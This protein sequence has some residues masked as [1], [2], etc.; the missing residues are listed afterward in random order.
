MFDEE[1]V[2]PLLLPRAR[3]VLDQMHASGDVTDYEFI[4]VDDGSLDGTATRLMS[5]AETWPELRVVRLLRNSG[6]QAALTAG[7]QSARADY[8]VTL[9]ADLQDPPEVIREMVRSVIETGADVVYGVRSDRTSDSLLKRT[10]AAMYYALMRRVSGPQ[11]P[12]DA[13]DFRLISRRVLDALSALPEHGRVYRLV[14][15]WFGFPSTEVQYVRP[16][17][18]AGTTKYPISKMVRLGFDSLSAFSALPLRLATWAGVLGTIV[19]LMAIAWSL[20]GWLHDETVPGWASLLAVVGLVGA[21]QLVCLGLLGEY[22]ARIFAASQGRPTYLVG[23]DSGTRASVDAFKAS[24]LRVPRDSLPTTF[25]L[26]AD[27]R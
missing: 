12:A 15:P 21:I 1:A 14:I 16:A 26:E 25:P 18:M 5:E 19:S 2:L 13:G 9:D 11:L 7:L 24:A 17:R 20:Y 10:T 4:A 8:V 27:V 3:L 22:V 6:H 23:Y